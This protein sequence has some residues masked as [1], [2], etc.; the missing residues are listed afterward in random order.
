MERNHPTPS[1]RNFIRSLAF[2]GA[3]LLATRGMFA[4][5]KIPAVFE[6]ALPSTDG[7]PDWLYTPTEDPDPNRTYWL[8]VGAHGVG[9]T[10][11][12]AC[13]IS[14]LAKYFDDVIVLG[15]SFSQPAIDPSTP[16]T[17]TIPKSFY[18]MS[19]PASEARL[20]SQI[21]Q[22]SRWWRLHPQIIL[23]G[24]SAGAQFVHRFAF[25]HP[26][27]VAG[28]AA[29]SAGTWAG[30]RQDDP[31]NPAARRIPFAISCGASD[32]GKAWPG[33]P[34]A[35]LDGC[36]QFVAEL[37]QQGFD[38]NL[39]TWPETEHALTSMACT[40]TRRLVERVRRQ[41]N[42]ARAAVG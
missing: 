37:E 10:G 35:R 16:R 9:E 31:I 33:A 18:Q 19:G 29:H 12:G 21:A 22:L 36:H 42:S 41:T 34:L 11:Q 30:Q 25:K 14:G 39:R 38:V 15:P 3:A 2:G 17:D 8:V 23:H 32:T 7:Q 28:V 1:R 40:Q 13:G 26:E 6:A 4:E 27:L 24:F 20:L 5:E